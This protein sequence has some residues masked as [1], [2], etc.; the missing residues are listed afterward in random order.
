MRRSEALSWLAICGC[1]AWKCRSKLVEKPIATSRHASSNMAGKPGIAGD[2]VRTF[3]IADCGLRI[4]KRASSCRGVV[5][6]AI[7]VGL[8]F[9]LWPRQRGSQRANTQPVE[10]LRA[11][12]IL[13]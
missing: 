9:A 5:V 13:Q 10:L 4:L 7:A 3:R 8:L 1:C 12:L 2:D 11:E 6:L